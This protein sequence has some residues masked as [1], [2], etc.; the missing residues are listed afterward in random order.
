[1]AALPAIV[2]SVQSGDSLILMGCDASRGPPPERLISLAGIAAPR[3][4]NKSTGDQPYA[5]GAREFLRQQ[6][7]GK[8]VTFTVEPAAAGAPGNRG[9]GNV[10]LEDGTSLAVLLASAGWVKP[11]PGGPEDLMQA[12]AAA[13]AQGLGLWAPGPSAD[14][15]RDVK[16]AGSFDPAELFARFGSAPQ[17]AIIEQVIESP[18]SQ[19][20]LPGTRCC[21]VRDARWRP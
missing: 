14:A 9:F 4:G 8:R 21:A 3:L 15:I 7:L 10:W 11:R 19:R 17:A 16:Y 20:G 18:L 1:M 13:E 12:S 5:W 2:K 6:S